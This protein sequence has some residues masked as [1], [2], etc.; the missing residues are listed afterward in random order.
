MFNLLVLHNPSSQYS[1]FSQG[2]SSGQVKQFSSS[3]I[4]SFPHKFSGL[5]LSE[6]VGGDSAL[7]KIKQFVEGEKLK[8]EMRD[9]T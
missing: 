7:D 5:S 9:L 3:S 8:K 2:T 1:P 4:L 6:G